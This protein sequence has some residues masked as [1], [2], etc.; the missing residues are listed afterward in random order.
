MYRN[1]EQRSSRALRCL[2]C[3][4]A[5]RPS[6]IFSTKPKAITTGGSSLFTNGLKDEE[7]KAITSMTQKAKEKEVFQNR[8]RKALGLRIHRCLITITM[9]F[10]IIYRSVII[11]TLSLTRLATTIVCTSLP[12]QYPSGSHC[13]IVVDVLMETVVDGRNAAK[14]HKSERVESQSA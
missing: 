14:F 5:L 7:R 11:I 10:I 13:S 8:G 4:A 3:I 12:Y 2:A 6:Q 9:L 1:S